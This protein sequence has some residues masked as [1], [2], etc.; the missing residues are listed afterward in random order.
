ML[1]LRTIALIVSLDSIVSD[2]RQH[3]PW[4]SA[5]PVTIALK[6]LMH[7]SLAPREHTTPMIGQSQ[8]TVARIAPQVLLVT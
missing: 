8:P 5:L 3:P 4:L 7:P 6:V 1:K 2:T